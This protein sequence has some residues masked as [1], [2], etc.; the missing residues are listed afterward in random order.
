MASALFLTEKEIEDATKTLKAFESGALAPGVKSDAELWH[1]RRGKLAH[2]HY[3]SLIAAADDAVCS[4]RIVYES[5]V[6]PQT[7]ET[8]PVAVRLSAFVPVNIPICAG[9]I[10]AAPTVMQDREHMRERD[11][12]DSFLSRSG[13]VVAGQHDLLAVDQPELQRGLQLRQPQRQ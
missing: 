12:R 2:C 9:M 3:G 10:I 4:L 1:A 5:A 8:L 7:G 13:T 6:H 11:R